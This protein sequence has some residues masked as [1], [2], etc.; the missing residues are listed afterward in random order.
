MIS[1]SPELK[2][3]KVWSHAACE[4]IRQHLPFYKRVL[5]YGGQNSMMESMV[6]YHKYNK[7]RDICRIKGVRRLPAQLQFAMEAFSYVS[8]YVLVW[9]IRNDCSASPDTLFSYVEDCIPGCLR[10][11]FNP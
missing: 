7:V 11:Y 10:P 2:N 1:A 9:W 6:Q 5:G 4:H 8:V 3:W